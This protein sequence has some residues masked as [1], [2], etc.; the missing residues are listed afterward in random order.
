[1]TYRHKPKNEMTG[2]VKSFQ[3]LGVDGMS[4]IYSLWIPTDHK[5]QLNNSFKSFVMR[6]KVHHQE[7][8]YS[9]I[10][11]E[12]DC[13]CVTFSFS[14][15]HPTLLQCWQQCWPHSHCSQDKS[16]LSLANVHNLCITND[17]CY[18]TVFDRIICSYLCTRCDN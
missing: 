15:T 13:G 16:F 7:T 5:M 4:R 14:Y 11:R 9:F 18:D 1:M 6:I 10:F 2:V 3:K 8:L 12:Y 17:C